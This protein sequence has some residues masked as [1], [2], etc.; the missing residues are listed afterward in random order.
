[1]VSHQ[2]SGE[3]EIIERDLFS[4]HSLASKETKN[5]K[6]ILL[7]NPPFGS[8]LS[9]RGKIFSQGSKLSGREADPF[10]LCLEWALSQ[11]RIERGAVIVPD[12]IRMQP[13]YRGLREHL[14]L[15]KRI[16]GLVQ[17]PF[18]AFAGATVQANLIHLERRKTG[19]MGSFPLVSSGGDR[20]ESSYEKVKKD[21]DFALRLCQ[22]KL[23]DLWKI[24]GEKGTPLGEIAACHEGVHTGNIRHILFTENP[25]EKSALPMLK[26][27]DVKPFSTCFKGRYIRYDSSLIHKKQGQYASL[28]KREI[29]LSPKLV[30]RQTADRLIV[31]REIEGHITDNSIHTIRI[32]DPKEWRISWLLLYLNSSVA[33]MLYRFQSGEQ[34]RPL[35]QIKLVFLRKVPVPERNCSVESIES[36]VKSA[37]DEARKE[38]K[39]K[40]KTQKTIDRL[41]WNSFGLCQEEWE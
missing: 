10:A 22:P 19:S 16:R 40:E 18:G 8:K 11:K 17:L 27:A 20:I 5:R 37:E 12:V 14:I 13:E 4:V 15:T 2:C 1:M 28:R 33:T 23:E 36:L 24:C 31:A 29:F 3:A 7:F 41:M 39:L 9:E 25:R 6:P 38:G 30:S 35:P 26:G 32:R 21:P 34:G